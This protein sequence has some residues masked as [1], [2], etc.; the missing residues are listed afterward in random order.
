MVAMI[1]RGDLMNIIV[2]DK[3][4]RELIE[5][6]FPRV[7]RMRLPQIIYDAYM[8]SH[9]IV[10]NTA[11]L[12][13]ERGKSLTPNIKNIA[14]EFFL[15]QEIKKGNLPLNWRVSYT[16]N[17]SASLIELY[18]GE[19]LLHVNQVG[20]HN[21]IARAA[22]C[23]DQYIQPFQS[24]IDFDGENL[25]TNTIQNQPKY[26]QLNHGYQSQEPLFISLGIPGMNKKWVEKIQLLE[27]FAVFKGKYPKS[28]PENI[29]EFR[30][31]EFQQFA[32]E[33]EENVRTEPN[34]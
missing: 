19:L 10:E 8:W 32:E 15:V 26:F 5:E 16:S 11:L 9:R 31:E 21:K 17:K 2:P 4:A 33:V 25:L 28:K 7:V 3:S 6:N 22:F 30:L 34:S 14:V 24:Y 12:N 27:E 1:Q 20:N 29:E 23:R 18:T 13:W